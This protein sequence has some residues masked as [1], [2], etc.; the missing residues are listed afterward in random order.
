MLGVH[1]ISFIL[2]NSLT[3]CH[4]IG[5]SRYYTLNIYI[6]SELSTSATSDTTGDR[7][8]S[9][10]PSIVPDNLPQAPI[11][12]DASDVASQPLET[13]T[14]E[15]TQACPMKHVIPESLS[16]WP[17]G[18]E[19]PPSQKSLGVEGTA[20]INHHNVYLYNSRPGV[21]P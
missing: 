4:S 8:T 11:K 18:K 5:C 3:N 19:P 16:I 14:R 2:T 20:T 10:E 7:S 15:E 1:L 17:E 12:T 9:T 21:E 6:H 13:E